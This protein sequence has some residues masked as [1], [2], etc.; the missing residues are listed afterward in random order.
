MSQ[1]MDMSNAQQRLISGLLS[2]STT[3]S[4][5]ATLHANMLQLYKKKQNKVAAHPA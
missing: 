5:P 2:K 1:T 3:L 4:V